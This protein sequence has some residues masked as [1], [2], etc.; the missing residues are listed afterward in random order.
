MLKISTV[1]AI[2]VA[3]GATAAG[4]VSGIDGVVGMTAVQSRSFMAVWVPL[5]VDQAITSVRWYHNDGTVQFPSLLATAGGSAAPGSSL[6]AAAMAAQVTGASEQWCAQSFVEPVASADAG[7]YV[8]FQL[9]LGSAFEH[10]GT[11]GG[12]GLGYRHEP[13]GPG[14]WL[15]LDGESW[16][17]LHPDYQLAVEFVLTEAHSGTLRLQRTADKHGAEVEDM[18]PLHTELL[19]PSP[20]PFNPQ[21]ILR[22]SLERAARIDLSVYDLRGR[23][24][25][26]LATGVYAAGPHAVTWLGRTGEGH[27]LASG[28]YVAKLEADGRKMTQRLTLVR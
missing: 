11:G 19:P 23:N 26:T 17:M 3:I 13:G 28:V 2:I 9:P 22:F 25:A 10:E 12:A 16:V 27:S 21:T 1:L 7:L 6:E 14:A 15:S 18:V 20:N 5:Q 4:A 8:M 24:V